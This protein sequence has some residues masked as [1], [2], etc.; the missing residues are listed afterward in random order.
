MSSTQIDIGNLSDLLAASVKVYGAGTAYALTAT[1]AAI[2]LGTTDPALVIQTPGT[3]RLRGQCIINYT[4]A[5]FAANRDVTIKLRRTNNTAADVA[6]ATATITTDIVTTA[7]GTLAILDLPVV[8]YAT[9]NADDAISMFGSVSVVPTAG[10]LDVV[11]AYVYAE[12]IL[13]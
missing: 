8:D 5:T 3:Y 12:K 10:S 11:S 13:T 7:T 4:G 1:P 9:V 2:D 6:N